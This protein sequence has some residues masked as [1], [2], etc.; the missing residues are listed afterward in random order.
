MPT[1]VNVKGA[2]TPS[3]AEGNYSIPVN[4][5]NVSTKLPPQVAHFSTK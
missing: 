5:Q 1:S 2:E 3:I 4:A